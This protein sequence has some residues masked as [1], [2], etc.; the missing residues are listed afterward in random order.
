MRAVPEG[1]QEPLQQK[2][3]TAQR[4]PGGEE[5]AALLQAAYGKRQ[6]PPIWKQGAAQV[7]GCGDNVIIITAFSLL[8]SL[9]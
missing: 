8:G 7:R 6:K 3:L 2:A 1:S 4:I 9:N 5:Q